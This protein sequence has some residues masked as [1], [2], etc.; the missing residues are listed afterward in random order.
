[1]L[2][3]KE[4]RAK[5]IDKLISIILPTYNS[6]KTIY[7]AMQSIYSQ[8]VKNK[9]EIIIIDDNSTDMTIDVIRNYKN[10]NKVKLELL[11]NKTNMGSG[12]CRQIGL[13]AAKG[14]FIA[15]LDSDDY[16]LKDKLKHQLNFFKKNAHVDFV[17]SDYLRELKKNNKTYYFHMKMPKSVS[18]EKNKYKN[19]IP[20]SSVMVKTKSIKKIPYP[21]IRTRNDYLYWNRVFLNN[22]NIKA[23]NS[24]SGTPLFIY[25]QHPGIS[26]KN[27]E[28]IKNQWLL[29]RK[30]FKYSLFNSTY[31]I[32]L[33]IIYSIIRKIQ[34]SFYLISQEKYLFKF[35][36]NSKFK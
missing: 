31:G 10:T 35:E 11:R 17:F 22:K 1:M 29:Y 5:D 14:Y 6:E 32:I 33:N 8:N 18:L 20:N 23:F 7:K 13:E 21:S 26:S 28:L 3:V 16:W 30:Y 27:L 2:E 19:H 9:L 24:N 4:A 25:S 36:S 15:F 34:I 12:F